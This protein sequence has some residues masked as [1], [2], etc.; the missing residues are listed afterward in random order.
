MSNMSTKSC[1]VVAYFMNIVI[2]PLIIDFDLRVLYELGVQRTIIEFFNFGLISGR[3]VG[4][5]GVNT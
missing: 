1:N 2:V 5:S 3:T 4:N